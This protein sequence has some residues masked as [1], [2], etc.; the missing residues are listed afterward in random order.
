MAATLPADFC[1]VAVLD[2]REVLLASVVL[3][4]SGVNCFFGTDSGALDTFGLLL[5]LTSREPPFPGHLVALSNMARLKQRLCPSRLTEEACRILAANLNVSLRPQSR[6]IGVERP[7][8]TGQVHSFDSGSA[9][10]SP[11]QLNS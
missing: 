3:L 1:G 5:A 9:A 6:D 10:A 8:A 11:V 4:C 7:C 2:T